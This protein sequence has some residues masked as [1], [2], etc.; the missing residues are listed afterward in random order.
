MLTS[1]AA[2]RYAKAFFDIAQEKSSVEAVAGDFIAVYAAIEQ[3]EEFK[4]FLKA[5]LVSSEKRVALLKATLEGKVQALTFEFLE[6]LVRKNRLDIIDGVALEFSRLLDKVNNVQ[7]ISITSAFPMADAEVE[8]IK[9]RLQLKLNKTIV[10]EVKVE[11][12]LIG[13]F[14]IQVNDDVYDLSVE[15]QLKMLKQSI[16][17]A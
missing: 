3:S 6:F 2:K 15:T 1:K 13:G 9:S 8:A 5:P 10:A 17:K 4:A 12:T 7:R 16:A 14:K 11:P